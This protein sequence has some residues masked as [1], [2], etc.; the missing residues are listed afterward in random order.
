MKQKEIW[1]L[2]ANSSTATLFRAENNKTLT[3]LHTFKHPESRLKGSDLVSDRPGRAYESSGPT[4]HAVEPSSW[5]HDVEVVNFA[6]ELAR[7]FESEL[8]RKKPDH[9]Y[10][11]ASPAF[12]GVLRPLLPAQLNSLI[13]GEVDKD[14][15]HLKV[16][17]IRTYLP[18]VL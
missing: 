5:P 14:I 13:K 11:A 12:L 9:F 18:F 16:D 10:L 7:F 2:V 6:R 1:V 17:E 4:R 3:A 8:T 15:T